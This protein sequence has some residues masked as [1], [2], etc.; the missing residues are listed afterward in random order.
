[1]QP[2][3]RDGFPGLKEIASSEVCRGISVAT[4]TSGAGAVFRLGGLHGLAEQ[5]LSTAS[6]L[7]NT[8]Q[9]QTIPG[10]WSVAELQQRIRGKW[11]HDLFFEQGELVFDFYPDGRFSELFDPPDSRREFDTGSWALDRES[12]VTRLH[13]D[14]TSSKTNPHLSVVFD[15]DSAAGATWLYYFEDLPH[16]LPT[17][18]TVIAH[19]AHRRYKLTPLPNWRKFIN[20]CHHKQ[21]IS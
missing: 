6:I 4:A 21:Q 3:R 1:M 5:G 12:G 8:T 17:R 20:L 9:T 13:F 16:I 11:V 15:L 10:R 2:S 19:H 18:D 14:G 7:M